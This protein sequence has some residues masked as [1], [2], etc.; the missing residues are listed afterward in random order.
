MDF[1]NK[2]QDVLILGTSNFGSSIILGIFWLYLASLLEKTQYGELGF[3]MSVANMGFAIAFL[4]LGATIV[5]YEPKNQNVFPAAFVLALISSSIIAVI[6]FILTQNIL[7]SILI[8][9]MTIFFIVQSGLNS[10]KRYRDFSK[11][12]LIRAATIVVL[13]ILLLQFFGL[14]GVL[15]GYFLA[16]LF[17]IKELFSLMKNKKISLSI[18]KPKIGFMTKMCSIRIS[19]VFFWWGDKLVIGA[20]FGFSF[21]ANYVFA[22]Q[23]LLLLD[24][25]PRSI[26]QYLL[27]QESEGL[28]NK[29]IKIFS[30]GLSVIVAIVS[31]VTIPFGVTNILPQ[32]EESIFPIQIMS[33]AIIPL[34]ISAIQQAEFLGKENSNIVFVGSVLQSI[35]YL[36]LIILL[37][38]LYGLIGI[39]VGFL[40]AAIIRTI[41]NL[42]ARFMFKP[43]Y[44]LNQDVQ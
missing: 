7:S 31:I 22:A 11:H 32:Y 5:V 19:N 26:S 30:V 37:G 41:F 17:V 16:S 18:L 20:L 36:L 8:L 43:S 3:L 10:K 12:V 27:P 34:F 23:Y 44:G 4:G 21:L 6:V 38:Q 39:A 14:N 29:K 13:S 24:A 33:I 35:T 1:L 2:T 42:V 25:I 28:K 15:L 9:G 40:T